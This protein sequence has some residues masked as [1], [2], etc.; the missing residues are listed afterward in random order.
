MMKES[1]TATEFASEY[2]PEDP[3]RAIAH[4][5]RQ[6]LSTI[7]SIAYYLS[8]APPDARRQREQLARIQQLVE[9][10]NWILSNG[11][12]LADSRRAEPAA[13]DIE[14]LITL[15]IGERPASIS[16][17]AAGMDPPVEFELAGGL[18]LVRLDPGYGRALIENVLGL[19]RQIATV[20]HPV[21]LRTSAVAGGIEIGI[22]AEPGLRAADRGD[23]RRI[24]QPLHRSGE[25]DSRPG[26]ATMKFPRH[27]CCCS[28]HPRSHCRS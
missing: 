6:P 12:G 28:G 27:G 3:L 5:I 19:F 8:L 11:L 9:Q 23:A 13:I 4:E 26:D 15:T 17:P 25:W 16:G 7:E 24:R 21:R 18:P 1:T 14:E 22:R 20:A 2:T 10:S